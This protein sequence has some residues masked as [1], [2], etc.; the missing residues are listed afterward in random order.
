MQLK[1][2]QLTKSYSQQII[3]D[4]IDIDLSD[5]HALVII[6]PSGSGKTT[7]LRC[8]AGL[9]VPDSGS[10]YIDGKEIEFTE[11]YLR[12]YRKKLGMVFQSYNLFPHLTAVQNITL[13]LCKIHGKTKKEAEEIAYDLLCRFTLEEHAHKKIYQLSGGQKQRIALS[14]SMAIR[15]D[16]LILD[17]PTSALDPEF[18]V[19]VLDMIEELRKEGVHLIMVTHHMGFARTVADQILFLDE[20]QV[21]A[22]D[23][24]A[25]MFQHNEN[26]KITDFFKH[27][28][29][30]GDI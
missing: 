27:T 24:P 7:L 25:N 26:P 16:F 21:I 2:E 11:K 15:P 30:Y 6:G 18:T 14:R 4:N 28:L 8:I 22:Q 12:E 10:M 13:P 20:G 29:K 19:E 9:A 17:E 5:F 1:T 3:L 23:L